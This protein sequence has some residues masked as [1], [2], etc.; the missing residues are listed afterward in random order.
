MSAKFTDKTICLHFMSTF[1]DT[2]CRHKMQTLQTK[3]YCL[4]IQQPTSSFAYGKN[5]I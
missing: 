5:K 4:N 2:L 1:A 3:I